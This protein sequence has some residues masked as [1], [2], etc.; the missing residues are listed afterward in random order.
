M[1][2]PPLSEA[3]E[4]AIDGA[5]TASAGS[6]GLTVEADLSQVGPIGVVVER[7][8]V[9]GTPGDITERAADLEDR[10][11]P[12]NQPM[13]A[14]E[15]D[16]RL[17]GAVLR[18]P[19]D[20]SRRFYEAEVTEDSVELTRQKVGEDGQRSASDFAVTR[21]QLGDLVDQIQE[22]VAPTADEPAP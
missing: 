10:L 5:G 12:D 4:D 22:T 2:H 9:R 11:R 7:V 15:V 13:T 20:R 18:S 14:I 1:S 19:V 3:L 21:E 8:K 17:G 16:P 6:D